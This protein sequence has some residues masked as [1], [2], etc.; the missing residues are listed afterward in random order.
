MLK[1]PTNR[2][3]WKAVSLWRLWKDRWGAFANRNETRKTWKA[4]SYFVF[5]HE[6]YWTMLDYHTYRLFDESE[7]F[8]EEV[9]KH[10]LKWASWLK[11]QVMSQQLDPVDQVSVMGFLP[12]FNIECNKRDAQWSSDVACAVLYEPE[13]SG[14]IEAKI[15][16]FNLNLKLSKKIDKAV[17]LDR[18]SL[19][20]NYLL[21]I[22]TA[23]DE[24]TK[25]D[26]IYYALCNPRTWHLY[27]SRMH[28]EW[29][30]YGLHRFFDEYVLKDTSDIVWT[31]PRSI[32]EHL[33]RC[34]ITKTDIPSYFPMD[35]T[36]SIN[37]NG[38]RFKAGN[39]E[40]E[41]GR[42]S[43]DSVRQSD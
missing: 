14:S 27:C 2:E 21:H 13:G 25:M 39:N 1:D 32:L 16:S 15:V 3:H 12:A 37:Q 23:K 20:V 34:T 22:Y 17:V 43:I 30:L 9:A 28:L 41:V 31:Q 24:T 26:K 42:R 35:S 36:S 33:W 8:D 4:W 11:V 10:D 18:Y 6:L 5:V 19:V 29:T 7:D 40:K 38:P